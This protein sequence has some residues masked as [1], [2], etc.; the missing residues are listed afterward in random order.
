MAKFAFFIRNLDRCVWGRALSCRTFRVVRISCGR[1][2]LYRS[3]AT[4]LV[5]EDIRGRLP[6]NFRYSFPTDTYPRTPRPSSSISPLGVA[7]RIEK[8][9]FALSPSPPPPLLFPPLPDKIIK[10][11]RWFL[12]C[13]AI[14]GQ[15]LWS[16]SKSPQISLIVWTSYH[17]LTINVKL[18]SCPLQVSKK[19]KK[20]KKGTP[21]GRQKLEREN[22]CP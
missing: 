15:L 14:N 17:T 5:C 13:C 10:A 7:T 6:G 2:S 11:A 12:V 9:V 22:W 1:V 19:A 3:R 21:Q 4:F 20:Q 8:L 16:P 18:W